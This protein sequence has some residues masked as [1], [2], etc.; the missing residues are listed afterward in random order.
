[1]SNTFLLLYGYELRTIP[2]QLKK[3]DN[4]GLAVQMLPWEVIAA[5]VLNLFAG[6]SLAR[7]A[8]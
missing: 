4:L 8:S 1:M 3:F 7:Y 2:F 5:D 6:L